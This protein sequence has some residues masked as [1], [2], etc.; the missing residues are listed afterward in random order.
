MNAEVV[1]ITFVVAAAVGLVA[2]SRF[3]ARTHG[4][5]GDVT[6]GVLGAVLFRLFLK[7]LSWKMPLS[8]VAGIVLVAFTGAL[9]SLVILRFATSR[10]PSAR[11]RFSR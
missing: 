8:G 7:V 11:R 3:P 4:R 6:V 1:L 10:D 9:I 2:A 5:I